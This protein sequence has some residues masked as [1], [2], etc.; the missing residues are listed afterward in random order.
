TKHVYL[1]SIL[2][3]LVAAGG[4]NLVYYRRLPHRLFVVPILVVGAVFGAWQAV[5][6]A[7]LGPG[8]AA[9]NLRLLQDAT[10]G[11]ALVFSLENM[12]RAA[13]EILSV[14]AVAGWLAP[15]L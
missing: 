2:P 15:A 11:A 7:G 9:D 3:G 5:L 6:I 12:R 14:R 4:L 10:R 1:I 8:T 13:T